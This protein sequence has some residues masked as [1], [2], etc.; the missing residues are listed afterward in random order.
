[1]SMTTDIREAAKMEYQERMKKKLE[2]VPVPL[3]VLMMSEAPITQTQLDALND[4]TNYSGRER[5][6]EV[7]LPFADLYHELTGQE[8]TKR[9]FTDWVDT[10]WIWKDE[11][12]QLDDI[13]MAWAESKDRFVVG[14][15]GALT[16]TAVGCKSK[17]KP[18]K[19][20]IDVKG[21]EKTTKFVEEDTWRENWST[22]RA[23]IPEDVQ[24]KMREWKA[25][26]KR[27]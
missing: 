13:R 1:M 8:C 21:I 22:G 9:S 17:A 16:I 20:E 10:F 19:L 26:I 5:I 18:A 25:R 12:L 2:G 23:P 15:P 14:R 7:L 3:D 24:A 4:T 11:K 6:P 27:S